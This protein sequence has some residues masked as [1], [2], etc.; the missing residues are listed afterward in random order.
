M[1]IL[2]TEAGGMKEV[3]DGMERLIKEESCEHGQGVEKHGRDDGN[4]GP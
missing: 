2:T 4:D 1:T 3:G